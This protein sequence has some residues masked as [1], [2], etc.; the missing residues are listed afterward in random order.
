TNAV[1]FVIPA[2]IV[3][4]KLVSVN[5]G[6][7]EQTL[8]PPCGVIASNITWYAVVTNTGEATLC[9]IVIGELGTG[10][11]LLPCGAVNV[12]LTNCLAP[13][14]GTGLIPL[15]T[16]GYGTCVETNID[17]SIRVTA[18]VA[19]ISNLCAI[20]IAGSNVV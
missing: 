14:Q 16:I 19:S 11:D 2:G 4:Q 8:A 12:A 9:N 7:P 17:N 20:N 18:T 15:C 3:C 6:T 5:G 13:G 1:A 10:P